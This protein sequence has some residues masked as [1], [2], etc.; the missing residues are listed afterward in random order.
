VHVVCGDEDP[1]AVAPSVFIKRT[2]PSA[3]LSVVPGTGHAV[4]VEEPD[5]FNAVTAGF[6]AEVDSGRWRPRDP[7]SYNPSTMAQRR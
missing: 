4:N 6:F 1:S 7:R 2:C 5:F 3:R